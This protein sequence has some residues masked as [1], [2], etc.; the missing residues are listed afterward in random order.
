VRYTTS[1]R[2]REEDPVTTPHLRPAQLGDAALD[3][4]RRLEQQLGTPL[5][6]YE[7]ETPY[8][9]LTDD[10]LAEIRRVESTLGVRLLAYRG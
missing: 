6:A 2:T 7:S 4:V 9:A 8:A 10:Q 5:V 3:D 1:D